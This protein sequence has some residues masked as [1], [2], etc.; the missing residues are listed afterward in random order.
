MRILWIKVHLLTVLN[1]PVLG[2]M[3][4]QR[5]GDSEGFMVTQEAP[6]SISNSSDLNQLKF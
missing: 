5:G 2:D 1:S 3:A 6:I 4:T